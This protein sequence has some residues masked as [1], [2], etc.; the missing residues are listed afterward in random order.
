[1]GVG[2]GF[3]LRSAFVLSRGAPFVEVPPGHGRDSVAFKVV[4]HRSQGIGRDLERRKRDQQLET[5]PACASRIQVEHPAD[6]IDLRH[7]RM[8]GDN[9]V[10][11]EGHWIDL[12]CLEVVKHKDGSSREPHEFG[13]GVFA[14]QSPVST[15]P[16]IAA[17]GAILRSAP[18]MSKC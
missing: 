3:A 18:M 1:M 17:T 11:A 14:P 7:V 6:R 2:V 5:P 16:L 4:D 8:A 10:Y 9:D 13:V 12:Q 15:F